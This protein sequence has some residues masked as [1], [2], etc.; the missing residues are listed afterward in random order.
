[1]RQRIYIDTSVFGGF[2]D[3][4]FSEHTKP[5][6]DRLNNEEFILLFST[7]TQDE[8][9]NAPTKVKELVKGLKKEYTEFLDT[10]DEAI[11]L[12]TEYISEKVVGQTSFADCL[13][14]ALA[15]INRAD[16]LISWNF[17]HIV[18]VQRIRGYNSINIKNGYQQ[19]EIRSPREFKKYDND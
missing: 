8:L 15:T 7:V 1:M 6:F 3:D 4:E 16:F 17:K 10:T 11:D 14:I 2:Y 13:H 19:L 12:A 5:L 9:E 18:N